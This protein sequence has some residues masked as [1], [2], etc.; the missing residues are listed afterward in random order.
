MFVLLVPFLF[1]HCDK[2]DRLSTGQLRIELTD[3]PV[4]DA[5]INGVFVTVAEVHVDG[6][7]W[8]GFNGR[9]TVDLK[10]LQ[11]GNVMSLGI[12][13]VDA[14]SYHRIT[15]VLDHQQDENGTGPGCY[16]LTNDN[17]KHTLATSA[18]ATQAV[19]VLSPGF[20]VTGGGVSTVVIDF[21]LRKAL[22]YGNSSSASS[23]YAFGTQAELQS[24]LR[25]V[26]KPTAGHINGHCTDLISGS[27]KIIVYAYAKGNFNRQKEVNAPSDQQ[28]SSAIT[29][30]AVNA[31]GNYTLAWLP[32]GEYELIFASYQDDGNN[33]TMD[34][35]GTLAVETTLGI[36]LTSVLVS[37]ATSVTV[38]VIVLSVLP[39]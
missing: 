17:T 38:N 8:P 32:P 5:N 27:E 15:L 36:D 20:D 18:S 31:Q 3:A 13:N 7:P 34:L 39:L 16:V 26:N 19:E 28:F 21:D 14:R 4:D 10:T 37:T 1:V 22:R 12:A 35:K 6:M 33:G 23:D 29:S 25:I 2:E 30:A 24:A 9:Q 11:N